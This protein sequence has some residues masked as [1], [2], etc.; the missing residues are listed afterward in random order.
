MR[1]PPLSYDC[2][3]HPTPRVSFL[4]Y[5]WDVGSRPFPP[6]LRINGRVSRNLNVSQYNPKAIK[7][8]TVPTKLKCKSTLYPNPTQKSED[9][10]KT[11]SHPVWRVLRGGPLSSVSEILSSFVFITQSEASIS[12]GNCCTGFSPSRIPCLRIFLREP[13]PRA[14]HKESLRNLEM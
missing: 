13:C 5:H 14:S 7:T 6:D 10:T 12:S 2:H 1:V 9:Q 4:G 11:L 3:P 8:L